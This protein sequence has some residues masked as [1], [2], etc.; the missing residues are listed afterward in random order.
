MTRK[1]EKK[2]AN[3]KIKRQTGNAPTHSSGTE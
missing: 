2:K 1:K 3:A